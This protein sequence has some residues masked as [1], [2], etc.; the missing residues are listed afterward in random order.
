MQGHGRL[1]LAMAIAFAIVGTAYFF[2]TKKAV[3]PAPIDN[4]SNVS[5]ESKGLPAGSRTIIASVPIT[6]E[7][8]SAAGYKVTKVETSADNNYQYHEPAKYF[9]VSDA[10]QSSATGNLVVVSIS[11]V[12]L[13]QGLFSYGNNSTEITLGDVTGKEGVLE[14]G[15]DGRG[16]SGGS[17]RVR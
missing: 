10:A 2:V 13:D 3:A 8:I 7:D 1:F 5:A 12:M 15:I 14:D 11:P 4:G 16:R 9:R 6:L 17:I